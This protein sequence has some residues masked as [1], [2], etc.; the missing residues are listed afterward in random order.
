MSKP[1]YKRILLRSPANPSS[2]R[3]DGHRFQPG[4]RRRPA[5]SGGPRPRGRCRRHDRRRQPL[6]GA[7]GIEEGIDQ[8]SA[9][10]YGHAGHGHQRHR[11]PGRARQGGADTRTFSAIEIKSVAEPFIRRRVIRH[12]EKGRIIIFSGRH[13]L[14]LLHHRHGR[15]PAGPRKFGARHHLQGD[16]EVDGSS[17]PTRSRTRPPRSSPTIRYI[18]VLK[19]NLKVMD[20][21]AIS[22]CADNGMPILIF[23]LGRAATSSRPHGPGYRHPRLFKRRGQIYFSLVLWSNPWIAQSYSEKSNEK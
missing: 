4:L 23:E 14:P 17:R 13:R 11:P 10:Q 8:G 20:A 19:K 22:L 1:A 21:T 9:D 6:R 15:R 5:R 7:R 12:M 16:Q 3:F 18:D 2:G